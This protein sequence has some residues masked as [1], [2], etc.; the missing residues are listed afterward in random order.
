MVRAD[1]KESSITLLDAYFSLIRVNM[2]HSRHTDYL[3]SPT[4]Q[5]SRLSWGR[6]VGG[7]IKDITFLPIPNG[8]SQIEF[9]HTY[10]HT[11]RGTGVCLFLLQCLKAFQKR[12]HELECF[13]KVMLLSVVPYFDVSILAP[14]S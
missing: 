12:E 6:S 7:K 9:T 4:S 1:K 11:T 14:T 8:I 10:T 2:Y 5:E 13:R 3:V